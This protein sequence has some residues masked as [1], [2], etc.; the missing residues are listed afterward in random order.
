MVVYGPDRPTAAPSYRE[1]Y[2]EGCFGQ[3]AMIG[4]S[5]L[6]KAAL[7]RDL[8]LPLFPREPVLEPLDRSGGFRPIAFRQTNYTQETTWLN[9]DPDLM[10]WTE[11]LPVE[12]WDARGWRLADDRILNV[13]ECYSPW[14]LLYLGDALEAFDRKVP[15]RAL[16]GDSTE[17]GRMVEAQRLA[18]A[19]RLEILDEDWR[20]FIKLLVALQSRL[21]P[22]RRQRT[23]MLHRPG[24]GDRI[25]PLE[26]AARAFDPQTVLRRFE[27]SLDDL[28]QLHFRIG[29]AAYCLD[30][31][32]RWYRLSEVAPRRVTDEVRGAAMRARDLYDAAYL[33]RG[34]YYLATDMWLPRVDEFDAGLRT[35]SDY[36]R[37]HLPKR[38]EQPAP[39]QRVHLKDLLLREGLYPH[40]IHFFVEGDTEDVV[41]SRLLP[42][43]DFALPG[44]GMAVTNMGGVDK[45]QHHQLLF[46]AATEV[47]GRAVLIADLEGSMSKTLE[48]LQSEGLFKSDGDVL[49]WSRDGQGIDFEEA[50]FSDAELV[51]V[52]RSAARRRGHAIKLSVKEV[53]EKRRTETRPRRPAP[54]LTSLAKKMAEERGARLSKK[55]DLAPLLAERMIADIRRAGHLA[56]AGE[57]RPL[58]AALWRWIAETQ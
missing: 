35:V 33:L 48:R 23:T 32:P 34:L 53:R 52:V 13:S 22:Y 29:D 46:R 5:D 58:L 37:R 7:A 47:S 10:L 12:Q 4:S 30:P 55:Q 51:S 44:S 31:V 21:W 14:Q 19:S 11:E 25:D 42:F 6:R 57:K 39:W 24:E 1:L 17:V 28:A 36:A 16:G 26:H 15:L 40:R 50:N 41:L 2:A 43:L 18:A 3:R 9:P 49:L 56:K 54:A 27:L 38:D 8:P 45:A 20:P